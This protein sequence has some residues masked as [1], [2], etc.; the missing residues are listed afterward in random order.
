MEFIY[1]SISIYIYLSIYIYIYITIYIT[2]HSYSILFLYDLY[3]VQF[4]SICPFGGHGIH[5]LQTLAAKKHGGAHHRGSKKG[6][7]RQLQELQGSLDGEHSFK[8]F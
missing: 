7:R 1:I 6:D 5:R 3:M 8:R 2:Y 4:G